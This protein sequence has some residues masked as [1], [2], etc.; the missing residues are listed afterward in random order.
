MEPG[1]VGRRRGGSR[2]NGGERAVMTGI[3][4]AFVKD[5]LNVQLL[6]LRLR[7]PDRSTTR[8]Q[9]DAAAAISRQ[10]RRFSAAHIEKRVLDC[11]GLSGGVSLHAGLHAGCVTRPVAMLWRV[12]LHRSPRQCRL[13]SKH[14]GGTPD[15][16]ADMTAV[17]RR[18]Y[19]SS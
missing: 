14:H 10:T 2:A 9:P 11:K 3:A 13:G 15:Q 17:V 16:S 5:W 1:G 12:A 6:R 7:D 8:P 4:G 18:H 19:L